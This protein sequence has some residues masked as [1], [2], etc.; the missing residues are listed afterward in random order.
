MAEE[1][2]NG[3]GKHVVE[4]TTVTKKMAPKHK[5]PRPIVVKPTVPTNEKIQYARFWARLFIGLATLGLFGYIVHTMLSATEELTQ[6]SKDLLN[7]LIG[8]FLPILGGIAK[9]YFEQGSDDVIHPPTKK[10]DKKEEDEE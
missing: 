10:D 7:L 2:G 9:Y 4:E 5:P 8:A 3:N 6:S 1:N